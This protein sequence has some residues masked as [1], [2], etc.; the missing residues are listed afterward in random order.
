M[1]VGER[2]LF[3]VICSLLYG[4]SI[5]FLSPQCSWSPEIDLTASALFQSIEPK[6]NHDSVSSTNPS[7]EARRR[8][9]FSILAGASTPQ[10]R[11][12]N[13]EVVA[14]PLSET[15]PATPEFR[16]IIK[17][18]L[19]KN[20][21]V[22]YT[23]DNGLRVLLCSDPSSNQ[24]AAAMDVHVGA[25]SDPIQVPGLAHF[26]EHMLFLGTKKY[27]K[28]DSFESFLAGQGGS[29]NAFTDSENTVYYFTLGSEDL[30]AEGLSRF[31]SFF[32]SPLFTDSATGRE[33]NAIESENAKCVHAIQPMPLNNATPQ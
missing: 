33:L 10:L 16:D 3:F 7:D 2:T 18:P 22:T 32:S 1:V 31:G 11:L 17:P 28:E 8:L 20:D 12:L 14:A 4:C 19:D 23:M 6:H 29:S 30:L 5:A 25:C 9:V 21:Y 15:S 26:T 27:P 13:R 24:A